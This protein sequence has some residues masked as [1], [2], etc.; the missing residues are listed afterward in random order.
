MS[1][2][3]ASA[4]TKIQ[5]DWALKQCTCRHDAPQR[6]RETS[7]RQLASGAG[8]TATVDLATSRFMAS[9]SVHSIHLSI[10]PSIYPAE[11]DPPGAPTGVSNWEWAWPRHRKPERVRSVVC[12]C[13]YVC[14]AYN[15]E[16]LAKL[17]QIDLS[18][19]CC[20]G[21]L[22]KKVSSKR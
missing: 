6:T 18:L 20:C 1:G 12:V 3:A 19:E 16:S 7:W 8:V 10:Y 2:A 14:L 11:F 5:P 13:V 21:P 4:V 22:E 15:L 17:A 9:L